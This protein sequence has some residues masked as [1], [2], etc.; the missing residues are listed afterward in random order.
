MINQAPSAYAGPD[1]RVA[2]MDSVYFSGEYADPGI[3]DIHSILWDFG[4]G[5]TG[6]GELSLSM[7]I[8]QADFIL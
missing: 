6:I 5:T 7:Y 4:D 3:K 8:I 2:A 1:Q